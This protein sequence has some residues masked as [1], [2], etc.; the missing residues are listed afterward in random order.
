[1]AITNSNQYDIT[2]VYYPTIWRSPSSHYGIA[3]MNTKKR[4]IKEIIWFVC[5]VTGG[6]IMCLFPYD[7]LD[8]DVNLVVIVVGVIVT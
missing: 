5:S 8:L 4:L 1:M 7:L 2:F 3:S 6:I